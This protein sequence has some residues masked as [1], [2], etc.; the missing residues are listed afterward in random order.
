MLLIS[1]LFLLF[2]FLIMNIVVWNCRGAL[3]PN[4]QSHIR[5]LVRCHNPDVLVVMETHIGGDRAKDIS[6]R[7]PFNNA[8]HT[9]TMGFAGG[10]WLMWNV[11]KVEV[12][13]LAKTEQ[14][15]HVEVKVLLSNLSWIFT[16]MLVLDMMKDKFCGKTF[17]RLLT[18]IISL[19]S[20]PVILTNLLRRKISLGVDRLA[21]IGLCFSK[22]SLISV[23]WWIWVLMVQN[24]LGQIEGRFRALFK[25]E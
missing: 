9:E 14:E 7:L 15:I 18:F 3:K 20:L 25:R 11:D 13:Q 10:I 1:A 8:I 5:E 16:A 17:R 4:F 24:I 12:V 6:D 19:G 21:L 23:I 2:S 22:N